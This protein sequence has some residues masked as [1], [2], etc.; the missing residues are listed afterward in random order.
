MLPIIGLIIVGE[1]QNILISK[2]KIKLPNAMAKNS[3]KL[4]AHNNVFNFVEP[5]V[6]EW[7]AT[8][9]EAKPPGS[10]P[11][12]Q[13]GLQMGEQQAM[14]VLN[15]KLMIDLHNVGDLILERSS[16]EKPEEPTTKENLEGETSLF[17]QF[18]NPSLT[19]FLHK[20]PSTVQTRVTGMRE[21]NVQLRNDCEG[22]PFSK[23]W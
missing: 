8:G 20:Q 17:N 19:M 10:T 6:T 22:Q 16:R 7:T 21:P 1:E 4:R 18:R 9:G 5:I 12:I 3:L 11:L 15:T 13:Q 2:I 14:F 23:L